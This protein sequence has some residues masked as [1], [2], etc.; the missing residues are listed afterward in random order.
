MS[1]IYNKFVSILFFSLL[2]LISSCSK[3]EL[4]D[5][6]TFALEDQISLGLKVQE[7]IVSNT[8]DFPLVDLDA[9]PG[10]KQYLNGRLNTALRSSEVLHKDDFDWELNIIHDDEEAIAITL[11]GGIIY[12]STGLLINNID[13]GAEFVNLI[14]HEASYADN[15]LILELLKTEYSPSLLLDVAL[16]NNPQTAHDI[17]RFLLTTPFSDEAVDQADQHG[18]KLICDTDYDPSSF[19]TFLERNVNNSADIGWLTTRPNND[20]RV[21][22]IQTNL[23]SLNCPGSN[24]EESDYQ[25]FLSLLP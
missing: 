6:S 22:N 20:F 9:A 13:N 15:D 21:T 18:S 2:I 14:A 10:L 19:I 23:N 7:V 1:L 24:L 25:L 8:W 12:I 11:P 4:P 17:S 5:Q 16:G 3:Q